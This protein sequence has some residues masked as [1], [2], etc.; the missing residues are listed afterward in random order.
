MNMD[1]DLDIGLVDGMEGYGYIQ[2][3]EKGVNNTIMLETIILNLSMAAPIS[4]L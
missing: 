1:L 2:R 3:V 4:N